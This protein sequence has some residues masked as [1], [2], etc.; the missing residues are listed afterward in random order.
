MGKKSQFLH[1]KKV[2]SLF[3]KQISSETKYSI[4]MR[5]FL[6]TY[7]WKLRF[8]LT[9]RPTFGQTTMTE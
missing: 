8:E 2:V 5:K 3:T 1:V 4:A 7:L 6:K 9:D